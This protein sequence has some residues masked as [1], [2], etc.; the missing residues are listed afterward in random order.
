MKTKI[1]LA[2]F[3]GQDS[4][5]KIVVTKKKPKPFLITPFDSVANMDLILKSNDI[6]KISYVD[7]SSVHF[8]G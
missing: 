4:R 1:A 3:F 2:L 7:M 8:A 5:I 6:R